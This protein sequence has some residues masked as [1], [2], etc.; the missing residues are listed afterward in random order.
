MIKSL[1]F[2]LFSISFIGIQVNGQNLKDKDGKRTGKWILYKSKSESSKD[3]K[4]EEGVFI[5]GRKEGQWIKY[6]E[7]GKAPKLKGSYSNNRP[8][9]EFIRYYKNGQIKEKGSFSKSKFKGE[10]LRYHA[11]GNIE[12]IGNYNNLGE[13]T[14]IIQ[15]F[16]KNGN[17][18]LEYTVKN[19]ELNGKLTRYFEDGTLQESMSF[20]EN[21]EIIAVNTFEKKI[22]E[23]KII[24]SEA[25]S[26]S[27]PK[28]KNPKTKSIKFNAF[29]YNKVYNDNDEIWMDGIFKNGQLWEG[30]VYRYDKEGILQRVLVYKEGKYH[31]EGQL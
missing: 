28:I 12:Y 25:N 31:S 4:V 6:F 9:G 18:A 2:I 14:G 7:D 21:G 30:K 22:P 19:A 13:E 24:N 8:D 11:N 26:T 15:Y 3:L 10:Y 23:K 17:L 1:V 16:H 5:H 20:S 27:P 29:G